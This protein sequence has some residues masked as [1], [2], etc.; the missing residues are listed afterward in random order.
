M[1]QDAKS[2]TDNLGSQP[3]YA[4]DLS[5]EYG[6]SQFNTR[7]R[8]FLGGSLNMW[9]GVTANP[10]VTYNSGR[11]FNIVTGRDT[12][13]DTAFNE[14]PSFA[15][16]GTPG[17][18]VTKYGTFNPNPGPNEAMIPRNYAVGPGLFSVNMRLSRTWGF[19]KR[20]ESGMGPGGMPPGMDGGGRG[21]P[22]GGGGMRG[23][24]GPPMGGM[25][26]GM[27]GGRPGGPGGFGGG[28]TEKRY[29][30]SLSISAR[31]LF[32]TVNLAPPVGNLSSAL[33]GLSTATSGGGFGGGP[34]GGGDG[35]GAGNRRFDIQLRFSF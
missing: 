13:G 4:Y 20:G 24:G 25:M 8:V 26:G 15:V 34:G 28:N 6:Q 35:S 3:A 7:R 27:G 5:S 1:L 14:R 2:D 21:G 33:F 19:G 22:G 10:F 11:P 9:K 30:L 32:N 18:I 12:N 23:G 16:A 17:A 29:N 31:N